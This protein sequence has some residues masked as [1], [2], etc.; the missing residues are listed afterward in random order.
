MRCAIVDAYGAG[1]HLPAAL[2][3]HDVSFLHVRSEF[4]DWRLSYRPE[5][6][7]VEVRHE[8]DVTATAQCLRA[9][10]VDIVVAGAE[11]GVLLADELSAALGT[12]GNGMRAPAARR[13]K[14]LMHQA[15]REAGLASADCFR[16]SALAD[17]VDWAVD[18]GRWPVVLKP[19]SSA[20]GDNVIV[21]H[22]AEE[23]AKA[24]DQIVADIDRYGRTND[25]ILAQEFLAGVEYYVNSVSRDGVHR[26]VEVWRYHKRSVSGRTVYDYEDLLA[27]EDPTA[28]RIADYAMAVLDALE[29]RNGAGHTEVMLTERGPVLVE[30]GARLGGGQMP[31]LLSRCTGTNQVDSLASAIGQPERFTRADPS[32]GYRLTAHLRCVNLLSHR[33]GTMPPD[34][35]WEPVCALPSF[36]SMVLNLPTHAPLART[37]DMA[38]CPGTVYLCSTDQERVEADYQRLRQMEIEG[39]Y[40]EAD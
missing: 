20:G 26:V 38:T 39:L 3:Q 14:Y 35:A 7:D 28:R 37:I 11:S 5:D 9:E 29:I 18:R 22:S 6:F 1:R 10:S 13:D 24:Y 23:I 12:P 34:E 33:R 8:G 4:P 17:I 31:E 27:W 36:D 16:S 30:C 2:R 15:V 21:C 40:N 25:V 32:E 19:P